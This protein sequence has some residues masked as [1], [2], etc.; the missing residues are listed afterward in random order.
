MKTILKTYSESYNLWFKMN[1][2]IQKIFLS[3][4]ILATIHVSVQAQEL[5]TKPSWWF[6]VASGANFNFYSGGTQVIN[7]EFIPP[8]AFYNG[9]GVGL[10]VAPT[11]E[12]YKPNSMFGMMLQFGYDSRKGKFDQTI[13]PCDC[14]QDMSARLNYITLEP[15]LRF[16]PFRNNFYLFTGP[17]LAYNINK[18]F[19]YQ[20]GINP[21]YPEQ[22][23]S[24]EET[25]DFSN[26]NKLIVSMQ[27]GAG[28]DIPIS[29]QNKR[30]QFV[31][32]PF[33]SYHP[34]FG[35]NPRSEESW[36]VSTIRAGAALKFGVAKKSSDQEIEKKEKITPIVKK[37]VLNEGDKVVFTVNAPRNI[38]AERTVVE[39]FPVINYVFF[40]LESTEIPSRY[41]SLN[42]NQVAEFK[43]DN[44]ELYTPANLSGRAKRQLVVY[45][46]VLNILGDR[47]IKNPST[48]INLVGSSESGLADARAMAE[49][50][51]SYLVNTWAINSSRISI[52]GLD[53]PRIPSRQSGA[54]NELKLL[55]EGDRRVSI[56]SSSP[57]LLMEFYSGSESPLK[58]IKIVAVQEAP[59]DSYVTFNNEGASEVFTSWSIE[60]KDKFG[61]VQN[62]GPYIVDVVAIPGKLILGSQPEGDYNVK[63][64]GVTKEGKKVEKETNVNMVLWKPST[65]EESMRFSVP[66]NFNES[67]S[68]SMYNKYLTEVV[69]PKIPNNAKVIIHGHTDIIGDPIYNQ[70]LSEARA[71]DVKTIIQKALAKSKTTGVTFEVLG[72][73]ENQNTAPFENKY[74]E[75]RSY[76]RTVIIDIILNK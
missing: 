1:L 33:V 52:E 8:V 70:K 54:T 72:L 74:P 42:K 28:F 15:S 30:T 11:I 10:Y 69:S 3:A 14:P 65:V 4:L 25:G 16:A 45:Y 62:F 58:P 48:S 49:S 46:N 27:V 44:V 41:V 23:P 19:V 6:G 63:M 21:A 68:I 34:Y 12:F 31:L 67:V 18:S 29:N 57:E 36:S 35:Q 47:M 40:D 53:K 17:R 56:E 66:F 60:I 13:T 22:T 75:E 38:P 43:E 50:V 73:G 20:L 64:I 24:P 39:T 9:F 2:G 26:I 61:E 7:D 37:P 5:V 32:S 51:K 76:N 55:R 59:T 71:N